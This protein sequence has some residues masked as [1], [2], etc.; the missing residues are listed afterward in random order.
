[1]SPILATGCKSPLTVITF[2]VGDPLFIFGGEV[3]KGFTFAMIWGVLIGSYSSIFI[4][5]AILIGLNIKRDW[6]KKNEQ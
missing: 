3:I 4:D 2:T 6:S 5:S 1:M